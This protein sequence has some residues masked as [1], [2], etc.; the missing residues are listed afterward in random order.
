MHGLMRLCIP[1]NS[2]SKA[3]REHAS[4]SAKTAGSTT[5]KSAGESSDE[6]QDDVSDAITAR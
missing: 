4:I 3:T 1:V 5:A 2:V 6:K